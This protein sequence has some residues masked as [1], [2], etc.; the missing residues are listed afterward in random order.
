MHMK[1]LSALLLAILL[2]LSLFPTLVTLLLHRLVWQL[3]ASLAD[4]LGCDSERRLLDE[5]ASLTG[6]LIAAVSI[7]SSVLLLSFTLLAHCASAIG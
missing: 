2:I 7:C 4:M 5:I 6:Y 3:S 1:K